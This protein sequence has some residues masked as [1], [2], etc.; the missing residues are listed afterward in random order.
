MYIQRDCGARRPVIHLNVDVIVVIYPPRAVGIVVPQS[1]QVGWHVAGARTGYE[2]IASELIVQLFELIVRHAFLIASQSFV[3]RQV[4]SA[5][6]RIDFKTYPIE[7]RG[8]IGFVITIKLVITFFR[9]LSIIARV[10]CDGSL[11]T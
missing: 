1:L 7:Q 2:Q 4:G 6:F 8:I 5:D 3:G 11:P 9:A 10:V